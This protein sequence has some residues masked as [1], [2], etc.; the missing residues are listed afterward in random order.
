MEPQDRS[1]K[2]LLIG[3]VYRNM[4]GRTAWPREKRSRAQCKSFYKKP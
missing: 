1:A 4:V 2:D 3:W